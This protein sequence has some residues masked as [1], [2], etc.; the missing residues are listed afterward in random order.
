MANTTS[1]KKAAR[2]MIRRTEIN[3]SRRSQLKAY[4]RKV[5]EALA[6]RD[7]AAATRALGAAEPI[8][9]RSAQKGVV[10]KK[11]A[12]RKVSRLAARVRALS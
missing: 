5:E 9:M 6:A 10:H 8:L 7:K 1:A 2:K 3:K 4:V 12:A 11:S